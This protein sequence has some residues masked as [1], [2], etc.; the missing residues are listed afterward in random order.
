[1]DPENNGLGNVH[2]AVLWLKTCLD[3]APQI[4]KLPRAMADEAETTPG[5]V[6][7]KAGF[8]L[9]KPSEAACKHAIAPAF[10]Q[11]TAKKSIN[12]YMNSAKA[13]FTGVVDKEGKKRDPVGPLVI[14]VPPLCPCAMV[15]RCAC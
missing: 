6:D 1:M 3:P 8:S 2:C 14:G 10:V 5:M 7:M 11:V 9:N 12:F 15:L 13:F 4:R